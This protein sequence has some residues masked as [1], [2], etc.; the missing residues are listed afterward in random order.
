MG[1]P[2]PDADAG[3]WRKYAKQEEAQ[4][5]HEEAVAGFKKAYQL[6]AA[7]FGAEDPRLA[8]LLTDLASL[9]IVQGDVKKADELLTRARELQKRRTKPDP[10]ADA[11]T[12]AE[13]GLVQ[14]IRG[15]ETA[16][17]TLGQALA[18]DRQAEP[19]GGLATANVLSRLA[20][21]HESRRD[22]DRL[23][24]TLREV[25]AIREKLL[26]ATHPDVGSSVF[27]LADALSKQGKYTEADALYARAFDLAEKTLPADHPARRQT[28]R[29]LAASRAR[30]GKQGEVVTLLRPLV[31]V[32]PARDPRDR[33]R[34]AFEALILAEALTATGAMDEAQSVYGELLKIQ[35]EELG[36]DNELLAETLKAMAGVARKRGKESEAASYEARAK[37]LAR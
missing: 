34:W 4:G 23:V 1:P 6:A 30:L 25:L 15:E 29:K 7:K 3:A 10:L 12:L 19:S 31:A 27:Q 37:S 35:E 28:R 18:L 22:L 32:K 33:D 26:P 36:A 9:K 14:M 13:V 24:D 21:Y 16:G 8:T 17:K 5:R 2:P 20:A 11:A